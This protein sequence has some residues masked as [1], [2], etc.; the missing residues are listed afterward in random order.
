M[1][2]ANPH[3]AVTGAAMDVVVPRKHGRRIALAAVVAAALALAALGLWRMVPRGLQVSAAELRVAAVERG[4]FL[5]DL[6]VRAKAE[7]LHSVILDS[8]E[9]GRVEEVFAHDGALVRQGDILFRISNPQRN[10]ELLQRQSEHTQQISNLSNLRVG[11][12]AATTEHQRRLVDLEFN[13]AQ[14]GKKHARNVQLAAK[15]YISP[16]AL[17]ESADALEQ[18]RHTLDDARRRRDTET[19]VKQD[20]VR[21]M[22]GAIR[23]IENGLQL[24]RGTVDALVVRAPVAGRLT[25]FKLQVGETVKTDQHIG[26]IDDPLKFKL[27]AQVDEYYLSRIAPGRQGQVR[28]DGRDYQVQVSCVYPQIKEGRFAV[29]LVFLKEQAATLNPGQS[30]DAQIT[31]GEPKQ[32]LLLPNAP[33]VAETGGAWVFALAANGVDAEKRLLQTGR[34]NNRQIEVL[35]GLNA[36]ERVI[37][38]SY[39]GF[40]GATRLQLKK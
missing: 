5:D 23:N 11:F 24:V 20:A 35:S 40:G 33:F 29:E 28:Q 7:A 31:L 21:K 25:D 13:L 26:R 32:A 1:K 14:A 3:L 17:E 9:A 6:I 4:I 18:Q 27:G 22:E 12:E 19:A 37:V 34:R 36:G 2:A 38:S 8:V 15:G 10:L 39:A 30:L 16:V